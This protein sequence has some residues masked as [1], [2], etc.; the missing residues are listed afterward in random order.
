VGGTGQVLREDVDALFVPEGDH[1]VPTVFA[2]GP[3]RPDSVHGAAVAAL[4]AAALDREEKTVAR[5]TLDMLATVPLAPLHLDVTDEVGGRRVQRRT[6][7]LRD[8]ERVVAQAHAMY[9]TESPVELPPSVDGFPGPPADLA[10]LPEERSGW[11]GFENRSIALH[12]RRAGESSVHGWFRL[13]V[14]AVADG[15]LT[16]LQMALAAADYTSAGTALVLSLRRFTFMSID[17]TVNLARRPAGD[18]VGLEAARSVLD[19]SGIGVAS[20]SLHDARGVCGR[21]I[22]TQLVRALPRTQ[23]PSA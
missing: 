14:P 4:F 20:S 16:G 10:L 1:L 21:C 5:I 8:G 23:R 17:L 9:V 6:A 18:W 7:A 3:W 11:P 15:P 22:E 19:G 2:V 13:L 12:T